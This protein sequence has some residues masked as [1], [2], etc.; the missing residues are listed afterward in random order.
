MVEVENIFKDNFILHSSTSFVYSV[1]QSFLE[2]TLTKLTLFM[3]DSSVSSTLFL[4]RVKESGEHSILVLPS[5]CA[6]LS[7]HSLTPLNVHH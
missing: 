1:L 6:I 3:L 4:P 7:R 2:E 5:D